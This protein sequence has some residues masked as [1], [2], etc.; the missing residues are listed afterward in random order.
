MRRLAIMSVLASLAIWCAQPA[1]AANTVNFH[2]PAATAE[3]L[4]STCPWTPPFPYEVECSDYFVSYQQLAVNLPHLGV[5]TMPLH[6]NTWDLFVYNV[7][8]ILHPGTSPEEPDFEFLFD[9][10][11]FIQD[12]PGYVDTVHLLHADVKADVPMDDGSTVSLSLVW[13]LSGSQLNTSG[14]NGPIQEEGVPWGKRGGD[15]CFTSNYLA[16]QTWRS[17][18]GVSGINGS[19]DR[20]DVSTLFMPFN[21]PSIGRG[22]FTIIE[23][24]HGG[25]I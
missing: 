20:V 16:H 12:V 14:N 6:E 21:A 17:G 11:G 18:G 1:I 13:D 15:R 25:C 23:T 10:T 5:S 9:R 19:L 3:L 2:H 7:H 22:V 8:Y 24:A 4:V